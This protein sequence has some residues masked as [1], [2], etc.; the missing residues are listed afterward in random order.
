MAMNENEKWNWSNE[1][2]K[3]V[4]YRVV[5]MI[6]DYLTD[7]PSGSKPV[8]ADGPVRPL[9]VNT[10]AAQPRFQGA[11][12]KNLPA[13][14]IST[15]FMPGRG[16]LR[17]GVGVRRALTTAAAGRLPHHLVKPVDPN[18]RTPARSTRTI[19]S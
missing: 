12:P 4:G 1:E 14:P 17:L 6:S 16:R 10:R 19:V 15:A 9:A 8:N 2:I 7:L 11:T 13:T 3:R 18:A 5:D